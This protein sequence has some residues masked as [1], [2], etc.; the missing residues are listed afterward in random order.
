LTGSFAGETPPFGPVKSWPAPAQ[1]ISVACAGD[2][3]DMGVFQDA[4]ASPA[5]P[6]GRD[7]SMGVSPFLRHHYGEALNLF[8]EPHLLLLG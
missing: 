3:I 7:A 8:R 5:S 4:R 2:W 1:L 6:P